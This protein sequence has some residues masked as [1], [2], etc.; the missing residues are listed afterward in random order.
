MKRNR[1]FYFITIVL[2]IVMLTSCGNIKVSKSSGDYAGLDYQEVSDELSNLGFK[3]ISTEEIADLP[4]QGEVKDGAVES[5]TIGG[6]AFEAGGSFSKESEV[7]IVYHTIK[8][9]P[10]PF[11]ADEISGKDYK[12]IGKLLSDSGFSNVEIK[13]IDDIDPDGATTDPYVEM[14]VS[15]SA[16]F[17]KGDSVPFDTAI[18]VFYHIPYEK[19]N[20]NYDLYYLIDFDENVVYS[21]HYEDGSVDRTVYTIESGDLNN[22]LNITYAPDDEANRFTLV[23]QFQ[24]VNDP[25]ALIEKSEEEE[26][27]YKAVSID[28]ALKLKEQYGSNQ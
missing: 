13:E 5:V 7:R 3:N 6:A 1:I 22:G 17:K 18:V 9:L 10:L 2:T 24:Y 28:D 19:F 21:F 23:L 4:S 14:T 16:D 27:E 11:D 20:V 15:G 26:T 25:D 12:V 8:T